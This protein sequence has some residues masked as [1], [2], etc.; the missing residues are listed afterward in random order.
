MSDKKITLFKNSSISLL[1]QIVNML[2]TFATRSLFIKY[3]GV[4]LL[5]LNSTFSSVLNALSLAE[6]GFQSAVVYNLYKPLHDGNQDEINAIMNILKTIYR[7]VGIFFAAAT[8]L[9]TPFLKTIVTG[10]A[11]TRIIY[12]YFWL[13]A[14]AS[15]CTY[16]LAY[17]RAILY[18]DQ[19]DYVSKTIDLLCAVAFNIAQCVSLVIFH[20]YIAYLLLKV[21]QTYTSNI[22]VHLFCKRHYPYLKAGKM[23]TDRLKI[24][25]L[26]VRDVFVG[27]IAGFT[28]NSTDNLVISSFVSTIS[29]GFFVNYTT[30]SASLKTITNSALSPV[31][32]VLGNHLLDEQDGSKRERLFYLNTFVRYLIALVIVIP[33]GILMDDFICMWVG[34]SMVLDKSIVILLCLDFYIHLVHSATCD[35][36][37]SAGLFK[38][39]KYIEALGAVCNIVTSI[40]LVHYLGIAGVL[41]GTV[42]SQMVFWVGRSI[43]V[44]RECLH[45]GVSQYVR[46]WMKNVFYIVVATAITAVILFIYSRI[47]IAN[48]FARFIIGG[49]LAEGIIAAVIILLLGHTEEMKTLKKIIIRK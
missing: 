14:L 27:R 35:F 8:F 3:I 17:K 46:Y 20:S 24:I 29:V 25:L 44:Y 47:A 7:G 2:F 36:I 12:V 31:I 40:V 42:I 5:G 4:E 37:N 16:F 49:V 21:A 22:V 48:M 1:S 19:K 11:V 38:S 34:K 13:Q 41:V 43:I 26:N 18:A 10:I 6:L 45:L 15:V 9:V 33:M 23:D 39:D 30:I 28:Y 32:P